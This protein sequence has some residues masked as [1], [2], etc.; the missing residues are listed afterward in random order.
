MLKNLKFHAIAIAI[1]SVIVVMLYQIMGPTEVS[2]APL[3]PSD[4]YVRVASASWG[5]NCNA[6]I[7]DA[8]QARANAPLA[9]NAQGQ[10]V[11]QAP[12][13]DVTP[14]NVIDPAKKLCDGKIS[15]EILATSEVL[16]LDPIDNCFKKL[17]LSYRC[18]E[19]DRLTT[20]ETNQGE[21]LKID[22]TPIATVDAPA[23]TA[24]HP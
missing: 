16:S 15:C 17:N 13:K 19:M 2:N 3:Q 14:N 6:F 8:K 12:L 20:T 18:F 21:L 10:V 1:I 23:P 4:R 22:C 7:A 11:A 24:T 5:L 9:K